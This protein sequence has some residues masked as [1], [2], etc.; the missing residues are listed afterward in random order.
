MGR[1]IAYLNLSGNIPF[2]R[3]KLN[4][5]VK[6]LLISFTQYFKILLETLSY[7]VDYLFLRDI[8]ISFTSISVTGIS[9]ISEVLYG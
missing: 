6:V 8:I 1:T 9:F 5:K 7:P 2:V 4:M 3:E